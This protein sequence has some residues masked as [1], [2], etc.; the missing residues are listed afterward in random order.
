MNRLLLPRWR[1][2]LLGVA[3]ALALAPAGAAGLWDL[4]AAA[5]QHDP[6][7][8]VAQAT[9][10]AGAA[11][12]DQ[13]RALWRPQVQVQVNAGAMGAS[14]DV[15]GAAFSAPGMAATGGVAF[16]TQSDPGTGTRWA[17]TARWPLYSP[18]RSAQQRQLDTA[19]TL[20][21]LQAASTRQALD[22]LVA[23]RYLDAV[24]AGQ[25]LA[26][27]RRQQEATERA[28]QEAQ[29][30]FRLGDTPVTDVR[31]AQA[32]ARAL[33]AQV[34]DADLQHQQA[35][36]ALAAST[37]TDGSEPLEGPV[38]VEQ[39]PALPPLVQWLEQVETR[40]LGLR[41]QQQAVA[42]A[43]AQA[44]EVGRGSG[45]ALD[46]VTQ[47]SRE[48]L[49][50][51]GRYGAASASASQQMLGLQL[52]VPLGTGGLRP[53]QERERLALVAQAEAEYQ[54]LRQQVLLQ[55]RQGWQQLN[56]AAVHSAALQAAA[57]ASRVRREA[58]ELGHQVGD[59]TT[60]DVL[61]AQH[62]EAAAQLAL[63]QWQ[64]RTA[65]LRLQMLAL[66]DALDDAAL[67][68]ATAPTAALHRAESAR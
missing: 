33:V 25:A 66:G 67:R 27:L 9:A 28:L 16:S 26:V 65:L 59:R 20:A 37:G 52:T 34:L 12:S 61:L 13:A 6:A 18:Q 17:L 5:R 48:H 29:D 21:D 45:V 50:G 56:A 31:E 41:Q 55:A 39:L 32:R 53:A 4:A 38:P 40:H 51:S 10:A 47:A 3:L 7:A 68:A 58:T 23:Q 8:A 46:L 43:R 11:R 2:S 44:A 19:A 36:Q 54:R 22:V 60:L 64:A 30:R 42:L 14:S 35:R 1:R 24:Q 49:S 57:D 63:Q 62:D 15:R